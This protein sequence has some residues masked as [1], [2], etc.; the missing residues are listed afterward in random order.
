MIS[1]IACDHGDLLLGRVRL[2]DDRE[3]GLLFRGRAAAPAA[4]AAAAT[5]AAS[6]DAEL[7]F[8]H[9][10]EVDHF[11]DRHVRDRLENLF[12]ASSHR[13]LSDIYVSLNPISAGQAA[14][15]ALIA[16]TVRTSFAVGSASVRTNFVTGALSTPS[17]IERACAFVGRLATRSISEAA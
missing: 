9:L 14:F 17:S 11:H 15:V 5:G 6:G 13:H 7:V 10:H 16:S 2:Q 3:L 1:R 4:A 12:L 8:H